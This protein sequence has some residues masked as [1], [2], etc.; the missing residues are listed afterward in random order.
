[1][2]CEV[3]E[4]RETTKEGQAYKRVDCCSDRVSARPQW[5]GRRGEARQT[6]TGKTILTT[7]VEIQR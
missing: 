2:R 5:N 3:D 1:M 4:G 7:S 6:R